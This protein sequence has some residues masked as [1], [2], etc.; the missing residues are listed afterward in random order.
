MSDNEGREC[1]DLFG[2]LD[3]NYPELASAVC[4]HQHV[5]NDQRAA[6]RDLLRFREQARADAFDQA[7]EIAKAESLNDC[8]VDTEVRLQLLTC[9]FR[10]LAAGKGEG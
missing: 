6:L 9:H 7:A 3:D 1:G 8:D 10:A 4:L 5:A 2:E